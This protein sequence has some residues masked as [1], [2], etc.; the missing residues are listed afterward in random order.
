MPITPLGPRLIQ[1]EVYSPASGDPV[2]GHYVSGWIKRGPSGVIGNN[3][4]DSV[5]TV[6][7][8]VEDAARGALLQPESPDPAAFE[9][10]V[11]ARQPAFVS[12]ADWQRLDRL[13]V[14]RGGPHGRPRR[15]FCTVEE[16]LAARA[17]D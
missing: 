11:R 12:F 6:N 9:A 17:G 15:K 5:E 13:E 2:P 10:L 1:P 7:V 8:L 16:M 3:K 14:E 4:A